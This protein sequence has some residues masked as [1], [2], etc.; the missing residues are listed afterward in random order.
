M[1][2]GKEA[3]EEDG[4]EPKKKVVQSNILKVLKKN[5]GVAI[6]TKEFENILNVRRQCINQAL[7]ALERKGKIKRGLVK[8]GKRYVI[9]ARLAIIEDDAI[10]SEGVDDK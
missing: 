8:E 1:P 2:I 4:K 10:A 5:P 9:Y 3:F 7:R 6:S